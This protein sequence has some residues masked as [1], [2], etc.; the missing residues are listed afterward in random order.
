VSPGDIILAR[1]GEPALSRAVRLTSDGYRE[2]WALYEAGGL[3]EGQSPPEDL[4]IF[5]GR[6]RV[7]LSS[8]RRRA[9]E[10]V[11]AIVGDKPFF[12][13]PIFVEA[14]L[15]P[16][17]LPGW[18]RLSPKLW[19]FLSRTCWW[20]LDFHEGEES[21]AQAEARAR[22][23]AGRLIELAAQGDVL[24]VAHGFFNTMIVRALK[25]RGWSYAANQGWKY[26]SVKRL[27]RPAGLG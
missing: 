19:G 22:I 6:A 24:L 18:I 25:A 4:I 15:P 11:A 17:P 23:A 8:T 5:A 27:K 9:M 21:R 16:P 7:L 12:S 14:P 1:H 10:S 2:W 13:D 26:W 3:K 20:F